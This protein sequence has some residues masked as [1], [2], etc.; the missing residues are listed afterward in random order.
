MSNT[1][2]VSSKVLVS[3]PPGRSLGHPDWTWVYSVEMN[4]WQAEYCEGGAVWV[5][6]AGYVQSF[7]INGPV[8]E[9]VVRAV[10]DVAAP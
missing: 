8:P 9:C 10:L 2:K 5:S 1:H 4:L 3:G 7:L 6:E